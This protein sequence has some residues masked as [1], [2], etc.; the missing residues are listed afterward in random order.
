MLRRRAVDTDRDNTF[1]RRRQGENRSDIITATCQCIVSARQRQ[2]RTCGRRHLVQHLQQGTRLL[3]RRHRLYCQQ[4]GPGLGEHRHPRPVEV[5]QECISDAVVA[6]ILRAVGENCPVRANGG[7]DQAS[8]A[9][10]GFC[11]GRGDAR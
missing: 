5:P 3:E 1:R 2:P 9:V 4:V 7:G 10:F 11:E 6:V 8:Y